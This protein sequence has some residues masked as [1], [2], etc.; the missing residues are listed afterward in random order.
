MSG[1]TLV[2]DMS[3]QSEGTPQV[4]VKKDWLSIIDN[5]NGNYQGNQC[6]LDTSQ[7]ANS[8]KYL[9]YRE[10]YLSVPLLLT[11]TQLPAGAG[12]GN[13]APATAATSADWC[14]GLKN[15]YGSIVHSFTLDYNGTTIVQQTP[16]CGLWNTFKLMTSLSYQDLITQGDSIGFHP[17]TA[18]SFSYNTATNP[19]GIGCSNNVNAT[20]GPVVSGAFNSYGSTNVGLLER[21][22]AWNFDPDGLTSPQGLAFST[23]ISTSNLNLA[24][25]SYI[26]KKVN[27]TGGGGAGPYTAGSFQAAIM[28][29]IKLKHLHSFFERVP[30]LKGVFMKMTLNLNQSSVSFTSTGAA[31]NMAISSINSPLGGVSPIMIASAQA[32]SGSVA[33]LVAGAYTASIAVGNVCLNATQVSYGTGIVA[34]APLSRSVVLCVPAYSFNPVFETSYLSAPIKKIDY[35]DIYQYQVVNQID[36][37]ATFNNLITNG[38]SSI[39]SVL[40]LPFYQTADNGAV[41]PLYSPFDPAGAGPT[42][43]L[44]LL[45]NFNVQVSGMNMIYNTEKYTYEQFLNQL[46]GVNAVNSGLTDGLTSGLVS[47]TDFETEYCYYYVDCSRMLPVEES[48]PKSVSI[49]GQNLSSKKIDLFVFVSYKVSVSIDILTGARI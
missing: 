23:L 19:A 18:T 29:T 11:L 27:A 35:T 3:S 2:F 26:Y 4:F 13:F 38:I 33:C 36:A 30:L 22:S 9:N 1:D 8:N 48:V 17:D 37:G 7:L 25:K 20:A 10:G 14:L 12:D 46:Y 24:Y 49:L 15:W 21:Q 16:Y 6:V 28:A 47:Q 5:Q 43:P 39:S 41:S 34:P 40:V 42:S 45:G 44:C 32:S 31:G